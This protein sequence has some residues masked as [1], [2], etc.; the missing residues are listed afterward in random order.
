MAWF[1][2]VQ[3][4]GLQILHARGDDD[5]QII[6]AKASTLASTITRDFHLLS[7]NW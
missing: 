5:H 4:T 6:L 1:L 7:C 3:A 2:I